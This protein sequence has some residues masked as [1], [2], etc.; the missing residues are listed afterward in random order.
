MYLAVCNYLIVRANVEKWQWYW[1]KN[2]NHWIA[3]V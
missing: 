3:I 2:A 1:N